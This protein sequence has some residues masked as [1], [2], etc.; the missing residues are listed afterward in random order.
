M[1]CLPPPAIPLTNS[2]VVVGVVCSIMGGCP[3][4][5]ENLV[6]TELVPVGVSGTLEDCTRF[7]IDVEEDG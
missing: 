3:R 2:L 7:G 4:C 6:E 5:G 1:E